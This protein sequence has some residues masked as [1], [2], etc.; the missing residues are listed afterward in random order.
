MKKSYAWVL[1]GLMSATLVGCDD[2]D[3]L[4]TSPGSS[5]ATTQSAALGPENIFNTAAAA[6]SFNT[7]GAA[8]QLT[9][10]DT[11]VADTERNFT[12]FAPT[13]AAF[14]KLG[15]DTINSLLNDPDTLS[16]ILLY[17]VVADAVVLSDAAVALAGQSVEAANGKEFAVSVDDG[18]LFINNAEVITA[19]VGASNGV[20]HVIDTVL[21]PPADSDAAQGNIVETAQT[22][23]TFTTL[24]AALQATGLDQTLAGEG[25]FT[26]FAPSDEAFAKL[27]DEAIN[28]LLA[29]PEALSNILLYHVLANQSVNAASAISLAGQSVETA[30][31]DSIALSL[32]A[33]NLFIN[34]S[35]VTVTD[36]VT[37][38]GIIHVID[39]VLLP[40]VA[41]DAS[42]P[43]NIVDVAKAQGF[44]TLLAA[45]EA[46]DLV[47]TLENPDQQFTVFA[48]TDAAFAALGSSAIESL[49]E[50]KAGLTNVLLFHVLSGSVV[51]S[52]AVASLL[53]QSVHAA[54]GG[55]LVFSAQ[56]DDIFVQHSKLLVTDVQ[57]SNGI[58]HVIDAVM[59]PPV[60]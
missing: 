56:G 59:I 23:G 35:Q 24:V 47:S 19:D 20:I 30:N 42:G 44:N 39:T 52:T 5:D 21:I 22:A 14:A 32:D 45:L 12:V 60:H 55:A 8:L 29:N 36:I 40:P 33:G 1:A 50:D 34:D 3:T 37:S 4:I 17:H 15:E 16:D 28:D 31:G 57:A 18:R 26:V 38:N 41:D 7:L 25:P 10:L 54:N 11:V 49:L 6:G 9:G 27:G 43:G 13:D 53:G 58:I 48:P 51:D 2:S 46:A